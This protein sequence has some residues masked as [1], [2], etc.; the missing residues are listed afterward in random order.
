MV[1]LTMELIAKGSMMER[2]ATAEVS[3][4][5]RRR[6]VAEVVAAEIRNQQTNNRI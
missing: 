2:A 3:V 6:K 4:R 5:Y 1:K